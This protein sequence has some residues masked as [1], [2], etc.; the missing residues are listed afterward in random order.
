MKNTLNL[1]LIAII[2]FAAVIGCANSN[3]NISTEKPVSFSETPKSAE[4][5]KSL[6]TE[7]Q[8]NYST[9]TWYKY[10]R[11]VSIKGKTVEIKTNLSTGGKDASGICGGISSLVYGTS[12]IEKDETIIVYSNTNRVLIRRDGIGERCQ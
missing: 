1:F 6:Q 4:Q 11:S 5:S 3:S 9:T 12:R 10:F 7:F 2:A 8:D